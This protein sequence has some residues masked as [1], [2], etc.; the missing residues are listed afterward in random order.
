MSLESEARP[1]REGNNL[2]AICELILQPMWYPQHVT[3]L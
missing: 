3:T 1:V 2:T